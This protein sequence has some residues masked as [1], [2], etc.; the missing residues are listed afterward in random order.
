[1]MVPIKE[2]WALRGWQFSYSKV[3]PNSGA[4]WDDED[5]EGSHLGQ[6]DSQDGRIVGFAST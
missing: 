3:N 2:F 6:A 1:M 5:K 4:A